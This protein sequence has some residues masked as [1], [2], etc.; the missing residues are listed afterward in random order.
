MK[1]A[2]AGSKA[3]KTGGLLFAAS[4]SVHVSPA[5]FF[6]NVFLGIKSAGHR[7]EEISRTSHAKDHPF[8]SSEGQYLKGV[9]CRII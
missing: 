9:F 2:K 5:S 3:N 7:F 1:I 6:K 8:M 4:L